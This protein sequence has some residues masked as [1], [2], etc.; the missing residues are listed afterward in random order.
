MK[1]SREPFHSHTL[2]NR[3]KSFHPSYHPVIVLASAVILESCF[4]LVSALQVNLQWKHHQ[5]R[6]VLAVLLRE[7]FWPVN[8]K[9]ENTDKQVKWT[10]IR[11]A[12]LPNLKCSFSVNYLINNKFSFSILQHPM[13]LFSVNF[14]PLAV[15]WWQKLQV[16]SVVRRVVSSDL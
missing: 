5:L 9:N 1:K 15:E 13:T 8:G 4:T 14:M 2:R 12:V 16:T 3:L 6:S 7:M 11:Q 10:R